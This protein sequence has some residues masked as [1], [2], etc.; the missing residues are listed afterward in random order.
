MFFGK[1]VMMKL[2]VGAAV[3]GLSE[4]YL[5]RK[6]KRLFTYEFH[7]WIKGRREMESIIPPSRPL[8]L[9]LHDDDD[10]DDT[11]PPRGDS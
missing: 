3:L 7:S 1:G 11:V 10:D 4:N 8:S 2:W 5:R 9:S 6:K